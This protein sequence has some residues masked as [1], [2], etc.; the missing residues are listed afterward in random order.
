MSK[1]KST[2]SRHLQKAFESLC[3]ASSSRFISLTAVAEN[4]VLHAFSGSRLATDMYA[5]TNASG[6]HMFM[7][8]LIQSIS[9]QTP[10]FPTGDIIVGFDNTQI[11]GTN[12]YV[13]AGP[14]HH[15]SV[16]TIVCVFKEDM[17]CKIQS[18]FPMPTLLPV[19]SEN[20]HAIWNFFQEIVKK[21]N[22]TYRSTYIQSRLAQVKK[23][24]AFGGGSLDNLN[25][26]ELVMSSDYEASIHYSR[27]PGFANSVTVTDME[28]LSINPNSYVTVRQVLDQILKWNEESNP[29]RKWLSVYCD[30]VSYCI[31]SKII[32]NT[33]EC[34]GCKVSGSK[35]TL[36]EHICTEKD[37]HATYEN[38]ILLRPGR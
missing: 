37:V 10:K 28:N 32:A 35:E 17:D 20:P 21:W 11:I 6:G 30:G 13:R 29:S 14:S 31:A 9:L 15:V 38:E 18:N 12:Y 19:P 27:V 25:V 23:E 22:N 36:D 24:S 8:N 4:L 26:R 16:S 5:S 3:L 2:K 7:S 33:F 34:K 1:D